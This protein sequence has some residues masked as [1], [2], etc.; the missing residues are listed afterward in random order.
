MTIGLMVCDAI[1]VCLS[2][3]LALW[4]RYDCV[5]SNIPQYNRVAFSFFILLFAVVAILLFWKQSYM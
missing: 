4:V 3:F 2:F 1:S 5:Y